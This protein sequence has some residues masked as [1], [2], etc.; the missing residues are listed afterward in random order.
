MQY[1][2]TK[3]GY[4]PLKNKNVD[5]GFGFDRLL[6]FINGYTDVYKTDLFSGAIR[7]LE[8][9]SNLKY[10]QSDEQ[11]RAMRIIA[12]HTRTAV[13]LIGDK[14]G[15]V[16]SNTGAGYILRRLIRRA[17]RLTRKLNIYSDCIKDVAKVYIKQVYNEAY[18]L[19]VKNEDY[20][21]SELDKEIKKFEA[22]L[23]SGLKEF[24][25]IV[26][27]I[28]RK[29]EF[30]KT[31]DSNYIPETE[32]GGKVAFRLYDTF[33]FPLEITQELAKENGLGVDKEGFNNAFLEH[34]EKSKAVSKGEFK[35]GLADDN[36]MTIMYHTATHLLNSAL[37]K[38]L[39][40]QSH[41]MGSNITAERLRFDFPCDHK[42]EEDEIKQVEDIVNGWIK[43][44]ISVTRE[45]MKKEDAA[46]AGA[47]HQFLDRYPDI[48]SVYTIGD[49][50]KEICS[51]P[52]VNNTNKLGHFKIV[53]EESCGSGIRRIKAVLE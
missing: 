53:K 15:I 46:S 28:N 25:K 27:G 12:D 51:G 6:M 5:T 32:I 43:D 50:S 24:E 1:E 21:I 52:H 35:S 4:V 14:D 31:K 13:M 7:V 9:T 11:T 37:K 18:P 38:V 45:E 42:L 40:P 34:Q 29:N 26:N 3:N 48:V 17:I 44:G 33:G 2:K 23:S 22:T 39:G 16:P 20:I 30:M 19:L 36:E 8:N 49:A 10:G 47:E 41:Q